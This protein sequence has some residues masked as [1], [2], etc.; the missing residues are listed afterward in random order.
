MILGECNFC[1]TKHEKDTL[2]KALNTAMVDA[3]MD[4]S[5]TYRGEVTVGMPK[6]I[7]EAGLNRLIGDYGQLKDRVEKTT[8]CP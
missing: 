7:V 1:L 2:T 5:K 8:I 6:A 4:L 3:E